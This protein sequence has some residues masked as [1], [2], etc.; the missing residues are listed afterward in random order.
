MLISKNKSFQLWIKNEDFVHIDSG[1]LV[2]RA[3]YRDTEQIPFI[4]KDNRLTSVNERLLV[5]NNAD[6]WWLAR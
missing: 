6:F 4:Y 1:F 3:S 5:I 2:C